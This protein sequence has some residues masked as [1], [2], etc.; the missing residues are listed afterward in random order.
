MKQPI[1]VI[2]N[3]LATLGAKTGVGHYTAELIQALSERPEVE[4]SCYYPAW[5][6]RFRAP[7]VDERRHRKIADQVEGKRTSSQLKTEL[8]IKLKGIVRRSI[9]LVSRYKLSPRFFDLYHEPNFIPLPSY[10]PTVVTIHDLSPLLYPQWHPQDRIAYF[11][12]YFEHQLQKVAHF[13]TVSETIRQEM[14]HKLG[15]SAERISVTYNGV[16]RHLREQSPEETERVLQGL[17]LQRG[18]YLHVGTI[19]PRKNLMTLLRAYVQLPAA[20]RKQA[21]LVLVGGWGWRTE[22]I[23]EY[24]KQTAS[25]AGVRHLGYV[26]EE[27]LPAL[28]NGARALL[29]PSHYEGFGMPA[30]E[31]MACGGTVL[32]SQAE[33]IQEV[34]AGC[35][36]KIS[37]DDVTGWTEAMQRGVEDTAW[38]ESLRVGA[39]ERAKLFTWE[40]CAL[41]TIAAYQKTLARK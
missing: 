32:A 12:R 37:A 26:T 3:N 20:V 16:R 1:R 11:Q 17:N 13:V 28:Y 22:E 7:T 6:T 31:M 39:K 10:L 4:V 25:P 34:L 5:F 35:G 15:I 8:L 41:A 27:E 30:A 9:R 23:Q 38:L 33:A 18:Y 21:P 24:F 19:E 36:G 29:Y 2:F 14:I 40:N